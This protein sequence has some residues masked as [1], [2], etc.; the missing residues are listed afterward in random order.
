[1]IR[2]YIDVKHIVVLHERV[3]QIIQETNLGIG[4]DLRAP[5]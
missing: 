1:M 5:D 3:V 2:F 4:R